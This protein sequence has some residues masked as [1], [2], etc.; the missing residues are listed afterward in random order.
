[1]LRG[2]TLSVERG[3]LSVLR[4]GY[5]QCLEMGTISAERGVLSVLRGGCSQC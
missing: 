4:G 5:S 2:G 1:M 3:V